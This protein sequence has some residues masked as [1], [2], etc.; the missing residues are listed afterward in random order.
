MLKKVLIKASKYIITVVIFYF[1]IQFLLN[2]SELFENVEFF[3]KNSETWTPVIKQ[4]FS[5]TTAN[6]VN[7]IG[8]IYKQRKSKED[9]SPYLRMAVKNVTNLRKNINHT[10]VPEIV[11]GSGSSFIYIGVE[12]ENT[13]NGYIEELTFAKQRPKISPIKCE[14]KEYIYFRVCRQENSCFKKKYPIRIIFRD[15]KNYF[16][17]RKAKLIVCEE[18]TSAKLILN[19]RQRRI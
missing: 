10:F 7:I 17:F 6:I 14:K 11:L 19:K 1:I 2:L 13:G 15:D 5:F 3:Q 18:T 4:M 9:S 16:Y 8:L 12:L